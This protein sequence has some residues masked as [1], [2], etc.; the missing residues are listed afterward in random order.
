MLK[1]V[2]S[3]FALSLSFG[4]V[5]FADCGKIVETCG[6]RGYEK[7][8]TQAKAY[9]CTADMSTFGVTDTD[10]RMFNPSKY[11]WYAAKATCSG[12]ATRTIQKVVQHY[13]GKCY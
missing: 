9:G 8:E 5:G 13:R 11:V 10:C 6:P 12:G 7:V 3:V 1:L 2:L 4:S